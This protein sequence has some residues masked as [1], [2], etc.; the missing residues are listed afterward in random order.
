MENIYQYRD[1]SME[2]TI[3][4]QLNNDG[5][6]GRRKWNLPGDLQTAPLGFHHSNSWLMLLNNK[7][8]GINLEWLQEESSIRDGTIELDIA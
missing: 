7:T 4:G 1:F 8:D 5:D 3:H 6:E 2:A